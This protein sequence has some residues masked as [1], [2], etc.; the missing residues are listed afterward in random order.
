MKSGYYEIR[1]IPTGDNWWAYQ[2]VRI[3]DGR[4]LFAGEVRT[5]KAAVKDAGLKIAQL[6]VNTAIAA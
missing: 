3:S 2:I 4:I 5:Y 6:T 1:Y